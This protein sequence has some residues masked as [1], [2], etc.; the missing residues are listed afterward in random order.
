MEKNWSIFFFIA[1][2]LGGK[3]NFHQCKQ[4]EDYFH[5]IFKKIG[6]LMVSES[7]TH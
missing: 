5:Q 4:N 7:K 6:D 1:I 2:F 3:I